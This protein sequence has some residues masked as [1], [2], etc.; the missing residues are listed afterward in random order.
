MELNGLH[1]IVSRLC[2]MQE[3]GL[4]DQHSTDELLNMADLFERYLL[5][6]EKDGAITWSQVRDHQLNYPNNRE[7]VQEFLEKERKKSV[8]GTL[9]SSTKENDHVEGE[10]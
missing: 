10:V 5:A 1:A 3:G 4:I 2:H 9:V 8:I 7:L 6:H